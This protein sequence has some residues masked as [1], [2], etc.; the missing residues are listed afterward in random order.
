MPEV[1]PPSPKNDKDKTVLINENPP[2]PAVEVDH[3]D[4]R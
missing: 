2:E 4:L 3:R 1:T